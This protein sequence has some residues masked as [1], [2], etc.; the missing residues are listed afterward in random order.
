LL[1]LFILQTS[2]AEE[3]HRQKPR[4]DYLGIIVLTAAMSSFLGIFI[5]GTETGVALTLR[6]ALLLAVSVALLFAF[7]RIERRAREPI[8]PLDVLSRSSVFVNIVSLLSMAAL[9]G[10]DVYVPIYLQNVKGFSPL[11]A[12]LIILPMSISWML[13]SIPLGRL[14]LRFGGKPVNLIGVLVTLLSLA[15]LLIFVQDSTV[16]F[17]VTTLFLLG[18]GFGIVLTTNTMIIQDSVSFEKRGAAVAVNSLVRTLGQTVGIS[19]F[20]A[21]FNASIIRSFSTEGITEYNLGNL[22]DLTAYQ[23]GVTWDQIVATLAGSIHV[24]YVIL[25][26]L[27]A[28]CVVLSL[29]MPRPVFVAAQKDPSKEEELTPR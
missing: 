24:V 22:Y 28:L 16:V 19:V 25:F 13:A 14:I 17:I 3:V 20:G 7:Y 29:I 26:I 12:G 21:F 6:S 23:S 15:P 18:V 10:V 1:T 4:I 27:M 9:M 11:I 2:Y 8:V 5:L